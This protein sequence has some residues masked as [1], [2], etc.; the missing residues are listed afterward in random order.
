ME[1]MDGLE[2][3]PGGFVDEQAHMPGSVVVVIWRRSTLP[4]ARLRSI[5]LV[6][7]LFIGRVVIDYMD[8]NECDP[9]GLGSLDRNAFAKGMW[10]IDEELRALKA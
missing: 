2:G 9:A 7:L 8:R 1:L 5:W 3:L 10:L 4:I 6:S